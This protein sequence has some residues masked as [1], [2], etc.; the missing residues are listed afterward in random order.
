M[1]SQIAELNAR[2]DQ[3][4]RLINKQL[5]LRA[6]ELKNTVASYKRIVEMRQ[7]VYALEAMSTELNTDVFN[8]EMEEDGDAL[9]FDPRHC[10]ESPQ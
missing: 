8:R 1:E 6:T 10:M 7:E 5:K 3:I 2:N 9:T 4:P